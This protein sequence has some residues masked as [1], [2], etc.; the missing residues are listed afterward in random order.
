MNEYRVI[1]TKVVKNKCS[2]SVMMG[3]PVEQFNVDNITVLKVKKNADLKYIA[4]LKDHLASIMLAQGSKRVW[5][6]LPE[7]VD[8]CELKLIQDKKNDKIR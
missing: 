5:L 2:I 3:M 1:N 7:E 4:G 8:V 6:I